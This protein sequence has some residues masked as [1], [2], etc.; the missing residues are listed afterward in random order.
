MDE[1]TVGDFPGEAMEWLAS[2]DYHAAS[3][4]TYSGYGVLY[5]RTGEDVRMV[6]TGQV[7]VWDE[8]TETVSV[9]TP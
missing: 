4:S 2:H 1:I 8:A 7:L 9:Q 6:V 5:S 3:V